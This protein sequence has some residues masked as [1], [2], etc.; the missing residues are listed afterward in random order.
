MKTGTRTAVSLYP[1]A[2]ARFIAF[3]LPSK[4]FRKPAVISPTSTPSFSWNVILKA[5]D[6]PPSS[7]GRT[8]I[9]EW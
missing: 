3:M 6:V 7:V 4:N 1:A 9:V 2:I 5:I 8:M